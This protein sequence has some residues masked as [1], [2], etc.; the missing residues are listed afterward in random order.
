MSLGMTGYVQNE[1][2]G[3][4]RVLL[5]GQRSSDKDVGHG[6]SSGRRRWP[7][8]I[9]RGHQEGP[10]FGHCYRGADQGRR[11]EGRGENVYTVPLR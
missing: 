5:A 11:C 1:A 6:S 10:A 9:P 2:N 4:V 3:T 8:I 7:E